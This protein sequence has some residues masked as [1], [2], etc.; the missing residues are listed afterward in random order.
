MHV[1]PQKSS[2]IISF[3]STALSKYLPSNSKTT[4]KNP[5][6]FF[7][8]TIRHFA[9]FH[10][11]SLQVN[12]LNNLLRVILLMNAGTNISQQMSN[13]RLVS[14]TDTMSTVTNRS[15]FIH[16]EIDYMDFF[17]CG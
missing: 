11:H 13:F 9:S 8:A 7:L 2:R 3:V 17:L 1:E 5:S 4:I 12:K 14:L 16:L 15:K 6:F 10:S